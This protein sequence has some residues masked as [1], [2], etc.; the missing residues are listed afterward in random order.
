[1][2]G[3]MKYIALS[4]SLVFCLLSASMYSSAEQDK[5]QWENNFEQGIETAKAEG[6]PVMIDFWATW[7]GPCKQMDVDIWPDVE[8]IKHS[9]KFVCIAVNVDNHRN[10]VERYRIEV[11]PTL[12]FTDPWGKELNRRKG[13]LPVAQLAP[14]MQV[15]PADFSGMNQW[16]IKLEQD[17]D[18][19]EALSGLAEFYRRIGICDL[20]NQYFKKALKAAG[21]EQNP[22]VKENL[23]LGMG[24]NY[25]KMKDYK[26]AQKTF[27][28][29]IKEIPDGQACDKALLGT[30]MAQ[31]RQGKLKA[32][33]KTFAKLESRYPESRA[34]VQAAKSLEAVRAAKR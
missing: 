3:K 12:V 22:L 9:Q 17:E 13:Y 21:A 27:E 16:M 25:M 32:A 28:K 2:G 18:S 6:K 7:C 29:C 19:T 10:I 1:M 4:I 15:F 24:L 26:N 33:E 5:I 23:Y 31:L 11:I 14:L 30:I 34:T 8:I 20:S